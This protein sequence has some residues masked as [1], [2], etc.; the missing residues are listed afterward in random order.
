M[1][2]SQNVDIQYLTF[3]PTDEYTKM[4]RAQ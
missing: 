1:K 3:L 4:R 2:H